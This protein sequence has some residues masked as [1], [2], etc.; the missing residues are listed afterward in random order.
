MRTDGEGCG[1]GNGGGLHFSYPFPI[2]RPRR[3][4]ICKTAR[5]RRQNAWDLRF[6]ISLCLEPATGSQS[7]LS[8]RNAI[9]EWPR[10]ILDMVPRG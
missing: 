7:G 1:R 9:Q 6:A 2:V 3:V 4:F 8:E 10:Q 5:L